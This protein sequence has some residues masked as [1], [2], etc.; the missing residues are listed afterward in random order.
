MLIEKRTVRIHQVPQ[1][2]TSST[3]KAFLQHIKQG[4]DTQRPR[5]V[6]D[7]SMIW[8]MDAPAIDLILSCLEEVMKSNGDVRLASLTV[9]A[10][11]MLQLAGIDRLFETFPS[12]DNAVQSFQRGTSMAPLSNSKSSQRELAA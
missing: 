9:K 5:M 4:L 11:D 3:G 7:C 8:N 10:A 2:L 12:V 6:L 1:Q